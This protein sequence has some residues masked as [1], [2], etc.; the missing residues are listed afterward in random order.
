MMLGHAAC[1]RLELDQGP[2]RK[3]VFFGWTNDM[4]GFI[5]AQ[6]SRSG[7]VLQQVTYARHRKSSVSYHMLVVYQPHFLR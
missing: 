1:I 3:K 5:T 2:R 7:L 4:H 6:A